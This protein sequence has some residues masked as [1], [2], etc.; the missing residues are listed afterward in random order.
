MVKEVNYFGLNRQNKMPTTVNKR[1]QAC[2]MARQPEA[3]EAACNEW[4]K[5]WPVEANVVSLSSVLHRVFLVTDHNVSK[6]Q[7]QIHWTW[8]M[9]SW[10]S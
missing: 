8:M 7:R 2:G 6:Q 4:E 10:S 3:W 9:W 1:S 5:V